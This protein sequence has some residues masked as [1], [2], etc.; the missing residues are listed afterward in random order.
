MKL[1]KVNQ[2]SVNQASILSSSSFDRLKKPLNY[3]LNPDAGNKDITELNQ[4]CVTDNKTEES[5]KELLCEN[6]DSIAVLIGYQGI[7]KSTD[8]RHSYQIMN[9]AIKFNDEH[10]TVIFPSFFRGVISGTDFK[11]VSAV[12]SDIRNDLAQKLCAVCEA[13]EDKVPALESDFMSDIG[14]EKFF[15]LF[16]QT[17]P[18]A[19]ANI[20]N[21]KKEDKEGKILNAY[22]NNYFIYIATKLKYYLSNPLC[23]YHKILII[24]DDIESLPDHSYQEQM[25][26][27]Y[28]RLYSCLRNLPIIDES[29]KVYVKMLLSV[30]PLTYRLL[31][32]AKIPIDARNIYKSESVDLKKYFQKKMALLPSN[33]KNKE[34]WRRAY[35]ILLQL[36]EKFDGKYANM[37][38]Q[39][40]HMNIREVFKVYYEILGNFIWIAKESL[41]YDGAIEYT[42]NNITVIRALACNSDKVYYNEEGGLIPNIFYDTTDKENLFLG[43]YITAYFVQKQ[44]GIWKYGEKAI[45]IQRICAD[46]KDIFGE[47]NINESKLLEYINYL[48]ATGVLNVSIMDQSELEDCELSKS[49]LIYLSSKGFELWSM[50]S[51]D[52]VLMEMYREDFYQEY[53]G[54]GKEDQFRSS[55]EL[56]E[57]D[58]Q[59]QVF[60]LV[61]SMLLKLCLIEKRKIEQVIK[62]GAYGKYLSWFGSE[63]FVSHLKKGVD[64]SISYSG[65]SGDIDIFSKSNE[66]NQEI[67]SIRNLYSNDT[68]R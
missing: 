56:M 1:T 31:R 45:S 67:D 9:D 14:K 28:L 58:K 24:L 13:L 19:L 7:G 21:L 22:K 35:D 16:Q 59:K 26:L 50:L 2:L 23:N 53:N 55:Y 3:F 60:L 12:F 11:D 39:L 10:K 33:L 41:M 48:Y 17:N 18:K 61:Y 30:R 4:C 20:N 15:K 49:N 5:L 43:L 29:K 32:K 54:N 64:N 46:F 34:D 38:K 27:Q 52:S 65:K 68:G 8:I 63:P 25:V 40:T 42:I 36:S 51:A 66:L 62:N 6:M 47:D 57:L 37:I 44:H